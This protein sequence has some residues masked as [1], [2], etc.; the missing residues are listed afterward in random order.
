M[1]ATS[2]RFIHFRVGAGAPNFE[3]ETRGGASIAYEIN[4]PGNGQP[5]EVNY[6]VAR[7][8]PSDNFCRKIGRDIAKGRFEKFGP[9]GTFFVKEEADIYPWFQKSY[10][11]GLNHFGLDEV[12]IINNND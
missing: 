7:C 11:Y 1:S 4:R 2:L 8:C 9:Q 3:P 5:L 10:E 6:R 12:P